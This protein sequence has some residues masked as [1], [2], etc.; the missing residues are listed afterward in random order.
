VRTKM[1]AS[2]WRIL[3]AAKVKTHGPLKIQFADS[4]WPV[5]TRMT[6]SKAGLG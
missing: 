1:A 3:D 6:A 2:G 5:A 4:Y